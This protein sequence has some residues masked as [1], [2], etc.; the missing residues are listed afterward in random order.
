M[1]YGTA[2]TPARLRIQSDR[3]KDVSDQ[4]RKEINVWCDNIDV[5]PNDE[6]DYLFAAH[7]AT[8]LSDIVLSL[9]I[10]QVPFQL[11]H[12]CFGEGE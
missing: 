7:H 6:R 8:V 9:I 5:G 12:L 3:Y 11:S 2:V 10:A 4:I 1:A